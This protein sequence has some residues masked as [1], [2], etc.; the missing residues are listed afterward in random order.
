[1]VIFIRFLLSSACLCIHGSVMYTEGFLKLELWGMAPN[2]SQGHKMLYMVLGHWNVYSQR[3][4]IL[5]ACF[6]FRSVSSHF[7][8]WQ[9]DIPELLYSSSKALENRKHHKPKTILLVVFFHYFLPL[10]V[11]YNIF[12]LFTW[13]VHSGP[14]VVWDTTLT[15]HNPAA[16]GRFLMTD[17]NR[18]A[19]Y[20]KEDA[21]LS[22]FQ[23]HVTALDFFLKDRK[24]PSTEPVSHSG[25]GDLALSMY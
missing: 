14:L 13:D 12:F 15:C 17:Q 4:K 16:G 5:K 18:R 22:A 6:F 23:L 21:D 8:L 3:S 24:S 10:P 25:N 2:T 11:Q 20:Q 9:A 1:M 19:D 7:S